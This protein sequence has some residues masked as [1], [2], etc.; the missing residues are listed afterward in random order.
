MMGF[1]RVMETSEPKIPAEG[2][3]ASNNKSGKL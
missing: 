1:I 2:E 3:F